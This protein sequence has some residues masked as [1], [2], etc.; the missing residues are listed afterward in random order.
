MTPKTLPEFLSW[1]RALEGRKARR[2]AELSRR[3]AEAGNQDAAEAFDELS[4]MT[5]DVPGPEENG[6]AQD[7]GPPDVLSEREIDNAG[8]VYLLTPHQCFQLASVVEKRLQDEYVNA[9]ATAP[10]AGF[11]SAAE[12]LIKEKMEMRVRVRLRQKQIHHGQN[13][14]EDGGGVSG[15]TDMESFQDYLL[16]RLEKA[17]RAAS[18]QAGHFERMGESAAAEAFRQIARTKKDQGGDG[19]HPSEGGSGEILLHDRVDDAF[20]GAFQGAEK[21]YRAFMEIAETTEDGAVQIAAQEH[22][23]KAISEIAFFKKL[24]DESCS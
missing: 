2:Y 20:R 1:A 15:V 11:R 5:G 14:A 9:S 23:S 3:A 19:F 10:D 4:R 17:W 16:K 24:M 7:G 6:T 12:D 21:D 13:Q 8:G 18:A 22:A